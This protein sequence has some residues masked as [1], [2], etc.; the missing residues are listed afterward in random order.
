MDA[1][2]RCTNLGKKNLANNVAFCGRGREL[3]RLPTYNL[4]VI[5]DLIGAKANKLRKE[6]KHHVLGVKLVERNCCKMR[7]VLLL[8]SIKRVSSS[9]TETSKIF[10]SLPMSK[11]YLSNKKKV[12]FPKIIN[13]CKS[14]KHKPV[15]SLN[16]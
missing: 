10:L 16:Q 4:Q 5:F 1:Y 8:L 2:D 14:H 7:T 6:N 12:T 15:L 13:T 9:E 3:F 11:Y